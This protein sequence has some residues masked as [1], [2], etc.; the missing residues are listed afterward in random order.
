M[1]TGSDFEN[2]PWLSEQCLVL[3]TF[4]CVVVSPS[5]AEP[6]GAA[7]DQC[8]ASGVFP[9]RCPGSEEEQ[10]GTERPGGPE[11]LTLPVHPAPLPRE[12]GQEQ[13]GSK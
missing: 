13:Q 11:E 10:P 5:A 1:G 4:P 9:G 2:N 3:Y 6:D 8:R 7:G 12:T